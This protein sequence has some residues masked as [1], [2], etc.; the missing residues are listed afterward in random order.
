MKALA[1]RRLIPGLV[2]VGML[3]GCAAGT[4]ALVSTPD[5]DLKSVS[6]ERVG[7]TGQTFLLGFE[8][9]NPNAFPLP[10]KAVKYRVMFD[11]ARFAGGETRAAFTV[12]AKG[13]D[14]FM[15][16]VELDIINSA[17]EVMSLLKGGMPEHVKYRV[18]G[19][20]TVDIPFA[21]PLPFSSSGTIQVRN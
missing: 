11:D 15:L 6:M 4:E 12:P 14:Q 7:F 3:A 1:Y 9:D 21:R 18:E 20:L 13:T 2:I 19:S 16:S 8:V 5:V 17:T 10:V